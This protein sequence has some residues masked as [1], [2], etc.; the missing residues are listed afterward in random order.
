VPA[1]PARAALAVALLITAGC[2]SGCYYTQLIGGQL[3]VLRGRVPLLEAAA[4]SALPEQERR[5]LSGIP[6]LLRYAE[7]HVQLERGGSYESFYD[8]GERAVSYNVSACEQAS[9]NQVVWSFPFVG[10][11]PYKGYFDL[12][13]ARAEAERYRALGYDA[14]VSEVRAYS[15][16]GWF[17]DP[18]FRSMLVGGEVSLAVTLLHE[19]THAT[20]FRE[21]D[22]RFSE[23]LAT[24][25]GEQAAL[26]WFAHRY[27]D[28]SAR[29][30][31]ARDEIRD[32]RVIAAFMRDLRERL[33]RVYGS[34]LS[35]EA[36]LARRE[37]VFGDASERL[38]ELERAELRSDHYDGLSGL[39]FDNCL[40]LGFQTYH[41]EQR[42]F[43]DVYLLEDRSWERFW[44]VMREAAAADDAFRWLARWR[45]EAWRWRGGA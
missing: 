27:G 33:S 7:E 5:L 45:A 9:F 32:G 4:D 12:E 6:E 20:I 30:E 22:A 40:V 18:V 15:T 38:A 43:E 39:R 23:S 28:G 8:T 42:A 26:E 31:A 19:L 25:V 41:S 14:R 44:A 35:D 37:E 36:K 10:S 3:A 17:E 13:D 1:A 2:A 24:F 11:V 29:L 16:L 34:D 21:G